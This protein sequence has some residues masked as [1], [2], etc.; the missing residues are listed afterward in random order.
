MSACSCVLNQL[1][2][3][4]SSRL[5]TFSLASLCYC[6][7]CAWIDPL[8]HWMTDFP[9]M[10]FTKPF[11]LSIHC[12]SCILTRNQGSHK[13]HINVK[14]MKIMF[15][16]F[17]YI[18]WTPTTCDSNCPLPV[19]LSSATADHAADEWPSLRQADGARWL[20]CQLHLYEPAGH[21]SRAPASHGRAVPRDCEGNALRPENCNRPFNNPDTAPV[22]GR[23]GET[24]R[25]CCCRAS[26]LIPWGTTGLGHRRST[27]AIHF[28][29]QRVGSFIQT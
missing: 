1:H 7:L 22:R 21:G 28:N 23:V 24:G 12:L 4:I 19:H 2:T 27:Q 5:P 9:L 13:S 8:D 6:G 17:L 26:C 10:F 29:W 25:R 16:C 18:F 11:W 14:Q 20:W 15:V 3:T